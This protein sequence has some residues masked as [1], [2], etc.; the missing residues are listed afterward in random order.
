MK[1]K[2]MIEK[3]TL[4]KKWYHVESLFKSP[5][6]TII[7]PSVVIYQVDLSEEILLWE[8]GNKNNMDV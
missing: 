3:R 7:S 2:E 8:C 5:V 6:I 4:D 1:I